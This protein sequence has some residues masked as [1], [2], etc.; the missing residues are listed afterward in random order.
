MIR[1]T[2]CITVGSQFIATPPEHYMLVS[3][4]STNAQRLHIDLL[5]RSIRPRAASEEKNLARG[6]K[7]ASPNP[8]GRVGAIIDNRITS[9]AIDPGTSIATIGGTIQ[10]SAPTQ[11]TVYSWARQ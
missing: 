6:G 10:C 2:I 4:A 3:Q 9:A 7:K 8:P 5:L 11:V 1:S